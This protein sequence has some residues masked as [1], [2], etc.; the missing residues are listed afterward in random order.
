MI[1]NYGL[2]V[3]DGARICIAEC[4][5]DTELNKLSHNG[6]TDKLR[7]AEHEEYCVTNRGVVPHTG[8]TIHVKPC[9][10]EGR[11]IFTYQGMPVPTVMIVS[12]A[13]GFATSAQEAAVQ[14]SFEA[15]LNPLTSSLKG[16]V[17]HVD[18]FVN[19]QLAATL[20][21]EPPVSAGLKSFTLD[22][23]N[24]DEKILELKARAYLKGAG[25]TGH[26]GK[27]NV[28]KVLVDRIPPVINLSR[29]MGEEIAT[30]QTTLLIAITVV[31]GLSG[32]GNLQIGTDVLPHPEFLVEYPLSMEIAPGEKSV[33]TTILISA[34]D[35]AGNSASKTITAAYTENT[36]VAPLDPN[37]FVKESGILVSTKYAFVIFD[38]LALSSTRHSV[39]EEMNGHIVSFFQMLNV[40]VVEFDSSSIEEVGVTLKSLME[41]Y[42]WDIDAPVSERPVLGAQYYYYLQEDQAP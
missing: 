2:N 11:Y 12:P 3:F 10:D 7:V 28:V 35:K 33:E 42:S 20:P 17:T 19:D 29:P 14:V 26:A 6:G 8:N 39:I 40:A 18:L 23:G 22:L 31:D 30:G 25:N 5:Q 15:W 27:S 16:D 38:R 13:D 4:T 1:V 36:Y 9:K 41:N 24:I 32:I 34:V 37:Y 21:I